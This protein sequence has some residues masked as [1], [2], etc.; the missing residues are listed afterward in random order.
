MLPVIKKVFIWT[1]EQLK[2]MYEDFKNAKMEKEKN[3]IIKQTQTKD[4]LK[5]SF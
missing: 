3:T 5:S 4:C 2:K 1:V